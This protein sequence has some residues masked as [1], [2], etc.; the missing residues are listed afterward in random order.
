MKSE[1][2]RVGTDHAS[3]VTRYLLCTVYCT[4]YV[5]TLCTYR[6]THTYESPHQPYGQS[7]STYRMSLHRPLQIVTTLPSSCASIHQSQAS[8]GSDTRVFLLKTDFS[9]PTD[10][11]PGYTDEY[12]FSLSLCL[13]LWGLTLSAFCHLVNRKVYKWADLQEPMP[14]DD[15]SDLHLVG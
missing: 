8:G 3:P 7:A 6:P 9:P 5:N 2:Q 14:Q 11:G 10:Q 15:S 12:R 4:L 13:S 1:V